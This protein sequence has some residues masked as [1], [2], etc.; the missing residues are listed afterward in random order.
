MRYFRVYALKINEVLSEIAYEINKFKIVGEGN[1]FFDTESKVEKVDII[2]V[3]AD[4]G[5]C[6]G[7]N[8][9]TIKIIRNMIDEKDSFLYNAG[10][11]GKGMRILRQEPFETLI[12]FI[13]SQRKSIYNGIIWPYQS[14]SAVKS[15]N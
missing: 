5:L 7:F 2:F 6:G 13:I 9:A 10:Q 1:K 4:K 14:R 12:S 8:V 15:K 3:T 11:A